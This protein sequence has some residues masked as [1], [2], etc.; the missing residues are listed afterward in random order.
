MKLLTLIGVLLSG[1]VSDEIAAERWVHPVSKPVISGRFGEIRPD[2][3]HKGTDYAVPIGTPIRV[4]ASG[5]V[6]A[7]GDSG[8]A[9]GVFVKVSHSGG[10]ESQYLH[11]SEVAVTAGDRVLPGTIIGQSG[12]T[13]RSTGPHLHLH[14]RIGGKE[15]DFEKFVDLPVAD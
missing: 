5:R 4:V 9:S 6:V 3:P 12:N 2:G 8:G 1:A 7:A 15:V 13:G 10:Q 14:F 11:L